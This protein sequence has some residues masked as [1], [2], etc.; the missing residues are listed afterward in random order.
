MSRPRT[1]GRGSG[2]PSATPHEPPP[3]VAGRVPPHDLDA[4]A[5]VLSAVLLSGDAVRLVLAGPLRPVNFYSAAKS[6]ICEAI[7]DL[8]AAGTPVDIV[9]VAAWLRGRERLAQVGGA[10]Y[11]AQLADATPAVAHVEAHAAIVLARHK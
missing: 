3:S 9:S 11:L 7:G 2:R 8:A 10:P 6:R 5:A 4:E 1:Q